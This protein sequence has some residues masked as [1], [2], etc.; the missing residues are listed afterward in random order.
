MERSQ[1][2]KKR[3]RKEKEKVT[4]KSLQNILK[5]LQKFRVEKAGVIKTFAEV[6]FCAVEKRMGQSLICYFSSKRLAQKRRIMIEIGD[7]MNNKGVQACKWKFG[8]RSCK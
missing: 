7:K 6:Q 4:F 1:R 5:E 3:K 2:K 8:R